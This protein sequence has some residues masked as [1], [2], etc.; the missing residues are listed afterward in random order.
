YYAALP[1]GLYFA[2]EL[3]CLRVAGVPLDLDNEALRLYFQFGYV[4]DPWTAFRSCRKLEP[5]CWLECDANGTVREGR[6]WRLPAPAERA[7]ANFSEAE[8]CE[9]LREKFDESVRI[10]MMADVP[11]GAFLSGGIDSSSVVASMAL[12]SPDPVKTFSI[13]FDEAEFN[14]LGYAK[15]VAE[16]YRTEHHEIIV[17]PNA[18]ELVPRLVRQFDEPFADSSAI[19]TFIVSEFAVKHVKVALSGDG[20]DE[21]FAGYESFQIVQGLSRYDRLP[22]VLRR[23]ISGIADRLPYAAYGKNYLHMISRSNALERYFESNYAPFLMRRALLRPEWMLPGDAAFLRH[24]FANCLL[25]NGAD[26]LSQALYFEATAKL[27]GDML[28]KVDR[29]SMANSL[30]VRSPM[31]DH[32]L[33]EMAA[34]IPHEWKIR[35]GQGKHIL[36]RAL[37]G[38]LPPELLNRSKM[39]FAV[40]LSPWLRGPLKEM[41][42]DHL[43]SRTFFDRGIVSQAFVKHMLEEHQSGRRDNRT[44]LWSLLVL[45]MWFR[46]N[47]GVQP[48]PSRLRP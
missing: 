47:G 28:V 32:E 43:N 7:P 44:W 34:K 42:W 13:G 15:L 45:E 4:P 24:A 9:R 48:Q 39:G 8:T 27:S 37:G 38:R 16:K 36:I 2:S 19:P 10:R 35:N 40:P 26:A 30:E 5:G 18:A 31:L 12:Q 14:E 3:K 11:L 25:P 23:A 6:Y 46:A 41:L 17:R 22:Q 1:T 21:L 33:A 20:G 29:M